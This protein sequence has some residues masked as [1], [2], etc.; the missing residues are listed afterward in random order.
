MARKKP[1]VPAT[2]IATAYSYLRFSHPEQ[3]KGD[4]L[5][6][7]E[8]ARDAWLARTGAVLDR[9]LCLQDK[10]VSGYTGEHRKNPDRHALAAFLELVRRGRIQ[11]GSYLVIENLDRLSREHIQPA[12]L[13][14]LNLLQAGVRIVQLKP[15][16]LIFDDHSDA[17]QVMMMVMEL[18]R[19]HS[20]SEMKSERV[21]EAWAQKKRSA[22]KDKTPITRRVPGWLRVQ[23]GR[24]VVDEERAA[25]V[26]R[27]YRMAAEGHGLGDITKIFNAEE[28][29]TIGRATYWARSYVFKLLTCRAVLGEYQPH[30]GRGG[31]RRPEGP[32]IPDYFPAIITE[33]QWHATRAAIGLR[34]LKG[35]RPT[36]RLNLFAGLLHD[37][38]DG[39]SLHQVHKGEKSGGPALASY[40]AANGVKGTKYVSF[41]LEV[42]ERAILSC[43]REIDPHEVLPGGNGAADRL[44]ALTGRLAD[45][46][47]RVEQVKAQLIDGGDVPALA[48]VLRTLETRRAALAEELA[49]AQ[50]QAASPLSAAW[51]EA[52]SLLATLDA[53]PDPEE[54]RLRLRAALRRMVEGIWCLFVARGALRIAA[55]QIWFAGDSCRDYLILH[56]PAT[57]GSVGD[58]PARWGVYSM[59]S[60]AAPGARDLRKPAHAK[61]LEAALAVADLEA[62]A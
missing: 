5:R 4:S 62:W 25:S 34:R 15:A 46:E 55:V 58:R 3:A 61:K 20:E 6:R 60:I 33:D 17:M 14:V 9:S 31:K 29:P 2:P 28:V 53:A 51:G 18:Q 23:A 49:E 38:R 19:G 48:D 40:R 45:V 7:Q 54:T 36:L 41:P 37:A 44:L 1:S 39:G 50:R 13:L 56:K 8:A 30:T 16:E 57:G 43:L 12:L 11:R 32:P 59:A 35:G 22:A 42:F 10:G 52:K 47:A 26:R 27:I 21:G 24:F